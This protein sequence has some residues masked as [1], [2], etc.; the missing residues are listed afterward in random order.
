MD[1]DI[2]EAKLESLRRCIERITTKT[3]PSAESLARDPD[4]QDIIAL[5]LQRAVQLCVDLAAHVIAD[6]QAR[7]PSTMAENFDILKDFNPH[8]S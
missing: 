7:V 8:H 5:N 1:R 2:V 6:T 3:P 4:L